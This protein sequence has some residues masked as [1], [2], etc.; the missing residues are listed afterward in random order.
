MA[1]KLSAPKPMT[2]KHGVVA[3][4]GFSFIIMAPIIGLYACYGT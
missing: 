1:P 2:W 4:F 3:F